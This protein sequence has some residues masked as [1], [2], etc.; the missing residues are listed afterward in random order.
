MAEKITGKEAMPLREIKYILQ[1]RIT[2]NALHA[3]E[4][5]ELLPYL[6]MKVRKRLQSAIGSFEIG[7]VELQEVLSALE[8]ESDRIL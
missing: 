1:Y 7:N 4:L 2:H 3:D 6:P 8:A 5:A